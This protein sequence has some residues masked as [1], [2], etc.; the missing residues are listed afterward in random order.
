MILLD[1]WQFH[2]LLKECVEGLIVCFKQSY[3]QIA[4]TLC[5][6]WGCPPYA[7]HS[8][9]KQTGVPHVTVNSLWLSQLWFQMSNLW[10]LHS[11]FSC[12]DITAASAVLV[13][14]Y[15]NTCSVFVNTWVFISDK[16]ISWSYSYICILQRSNSDELYWQI[17]LLAALLL[18]WQVGQSTSLVPDEISQQHDW[19]S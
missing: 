4:I 19:L 14:Q 1:F 3:P 6:Q 17:A 10:W 15:L 7:T 2:L 12:G 8:L 16:T 11:S 13:F 18:G 9:W 5:S